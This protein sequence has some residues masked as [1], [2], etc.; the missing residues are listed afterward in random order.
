MADY[1]KDMAEERIQISNDEQKIYEDDKKKRDSSNKMLA[2]NSPAKNQNK[3]YAD[4]R[5]LTDMPLTKDM[6]G[7]RGMS[8]M[9]KHATQRFSSPVKAHLSPD[10]ESK[11]PSELKAAMHYNKDEKDGSMAKMV[12][13]LKDQGYNAR[14]DDSLGGQ[15]GHK[16]QS[17]AGRRH[18]SEAME[19]HFGHNKFSSDSKM[20]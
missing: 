12:S 18:E 16:S 11:L 7:G 10:Q 13:P 8:W 20:S 1:D 3:G 5:E 19:K 6:T 14:L 4:S 15:H 17:L 2:S 9:S